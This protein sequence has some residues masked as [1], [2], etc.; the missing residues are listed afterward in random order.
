[1]TVVKESNIIGDFLGYGCGRVYRLADGSVWTQ[2]G[3][4]D[5]PCWRESPRCRIFFN[6]STNQHYLDVDGTSGVAEV[7]EGLRRQ[8]HTGGF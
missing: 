5:E 3:P 1:M 8:P 2:E 6:Q 4:T 7:V